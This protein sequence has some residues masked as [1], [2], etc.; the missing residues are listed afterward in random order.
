MDSCSEDIY[1]KPLITVIGQGDIA[2]YFTF[3][4]YFDWPPAA[5]ENKLPCSLDSESR[6]KLDHFTLLSWDTYVKIYL[7]F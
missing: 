3:K 1:N 4:H 6:N 2:R 5:H 7:K